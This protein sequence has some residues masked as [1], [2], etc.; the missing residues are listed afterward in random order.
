MGLTEDEFVR[1]NRCRIYLQVLLLSDIVDA[2]GIHL[3]HSYLQ[4][5]R[6]TTRKSI[7][8]WPQQGKPPVHDWVLWQSSIQRTYSNIGSTRLQYSL[9]A[10]IAKPHQTW[11]WFKNLIT[12]DLYRKCDNFYDELDRSNRWYVVQKSRHPTQCTTKIS[13]SMHH[14]SSY[15]QPHPAH[16]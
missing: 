15:S 6:S 2:G 9:G 1:V 13:I 5:R 4:G 3:L 11:T 7:L 10:W 16:Q 12:N 8:K 14:K